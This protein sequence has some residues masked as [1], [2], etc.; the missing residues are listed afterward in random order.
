MHILSWIADPTAGPTYCH[1]TGNLKALSS[2]MNSSTSPQTCFSSC[3]LYLDEQKHN[4][5]SCPN[6]KSL[7]HLWLY[8]L[9]YPSYPVGLQVWVI[10]VPCYLWNPSGAVNVPGPCPSSGAQQL[11]L[12]L[13]VLFP[14]LLCSLASIQPPPPC[15]HSHVLK[16]KTQLPHCHFYNFQSMEQSSDSLASYASSSRSGLYQ[17]ASPKLGHTPSTND[18]DGPAVPVSS[19]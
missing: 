10:L 1:F 3:I 7:S 5:L 4:P 15:H 9:L 18:T 6:Q 17:P 8:P 16:H 2:R 14:P 13:V 11:L 19:W 12:P